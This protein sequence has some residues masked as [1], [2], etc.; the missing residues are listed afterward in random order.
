[1]K[2]EVPE[3]IAKGGSTNPHSEGE[4]EVESRRKGTSKVRLITTG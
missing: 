4:K 3:R 2:E 1:M